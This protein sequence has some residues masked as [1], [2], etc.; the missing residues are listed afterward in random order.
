VIKV[1]KRVE[2]LG[3]KMYLIVG[4]GNPEP[5]YSK[6]RHNMGFDVINKLAK[7]YEIELSRSNFEGIYGTGIIENEK[8]IL[9][10]PQTYMNLSGQSIKKY[11]DFY[12]IPLE[13]ILVVFDDMDTEKGKIKIRKMGGPG[14]HNGAKSVVHE[15]QSEQF[16][17]IRVGIGRPID[18]D[19]IIDYVIT[20]IQNEQEYK[21]LEIGIE[22]AKDAII[23]Y[24]KNGIDKAMNKF[25]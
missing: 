15:L 3:G 6:T 18:N 25:N 10:K 13:N 17:R 24:L 12:K 20:P 2:K 22:K 19:E 14:T 8:V 4:L 1:L 7:Q 21:Q 9:L 23:E 16:A 5:E 11:I